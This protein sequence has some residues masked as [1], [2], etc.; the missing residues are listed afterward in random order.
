MGFKR[1]KED[2]NVAGTRYRY[3][4]PECRDTN[5]TFFYNNVTEPLFCTLIPPDAGEEA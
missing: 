5:V 2:Q 4:G 3:S 1:P